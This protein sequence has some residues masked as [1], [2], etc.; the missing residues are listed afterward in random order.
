MGMEKGSEREKLERGV[1]IFIR[2]KVIIF[3][4]VCSLDLQ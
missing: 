1:Y 3:R 2:V 4:T